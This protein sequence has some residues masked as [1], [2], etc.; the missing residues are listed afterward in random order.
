MR[1]LWEWGTGRR[2]PWLGALAAAVLALSLGVYFIFAPASGLNAAV[3]RTAE[4]IMPIK[5]WG[6]VFLVKGCA[7]IA[8]FAARS[9]LNLYR[10]MV[11]GVGL[12]LVWAIIAAYTAYTTEWAGTVAAA[13]WAWTAFSHYL[14]RRR[15]LAAYRADVGVE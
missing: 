12:Y 10:V 5:W 6:V 9:W 14:L 8:A 3:Y 13:L 7:A 11:A 2:E 15:F 4:D 1:S